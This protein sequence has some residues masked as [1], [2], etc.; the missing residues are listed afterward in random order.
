MLRTLG[1]DVS[2]GVEVSVEDDVSR[3]L[4]QSQR[5]D[6]NVQGFE[7]ALDHVELFI[8]TEPEHS[9][10]ALVHEVVVRISNERPISGV[11]ALA[12]SVHDEHAV[13]FDGEGPC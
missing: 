4:R 13:A 9:C 11:V 3:G 7:V 6:W 8:D 1:S 10:T 12:G 2:G 5:A